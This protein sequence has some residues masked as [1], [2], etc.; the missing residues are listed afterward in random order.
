MIKMTE[1]TAEQIQQKFS[2]LGVEINQADI[3]KRLD[4]LTVRFKVPAQEAQRSVV[5]YFLRE[6]DIKREDYY[7]AQGDSQTTQINDIT[8]SG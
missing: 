1:Q 7:G 6:H 3:S 5:A 8:E 2:E 4:D